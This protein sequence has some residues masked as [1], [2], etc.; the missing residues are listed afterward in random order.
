MKFSSTE[1]KNQSR[2]LLTQA[3]VWFQQR[4]CP[5]DVTL[6]ISECPAAGKLYKHTEIFVFEQSSSEG[7]WE[8]HPGPQLSI[9]GSCINTNLSKLILH[10][11]AFQL[12]H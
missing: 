3:F 4:V 9:K 2:Y 10:Y 1:L 12:N 7:G 6:L 11:L 8:G 5:V